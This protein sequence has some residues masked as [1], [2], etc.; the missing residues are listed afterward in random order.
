MEA[1][2]LSMGMEVTDKQGGRL[3][4]FMVCWI[5]IGDINMNSCLVYY[6]DGWYRN[7]YRYV[8][9]HGLVHIHELP[10]VTVELI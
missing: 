1:K 7:T 2:F 3:E 10:S 6:K 4:G 5:R 9:I 8:Y